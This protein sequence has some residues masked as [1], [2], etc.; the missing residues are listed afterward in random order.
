MRTSGYGKI[1]LI[2][3]DG[4]RVPTPSEAIVGSAAAA[5]VFMTRAVARELARDGVR[6]NSLAITLTKD[7]PGHDR[8]VERQADGS[9]GVLDQ[10]FARLEAKM[11]FGLG[12]AAEV[13]DLAAFLLA[14]ETDGITGAT[15]SVNRGGY[16]PVYA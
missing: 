14:P 9:G 11:P 10:A 6:V 13:A 7:T 4:G 1:V 16:F 2:T 3:S 15:I 5:V 12:A 8:M